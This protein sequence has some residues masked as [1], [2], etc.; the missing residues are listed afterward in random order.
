MLVRVISKFDVG[1]E[2]IFFGR[3]SPVDRSDRWTCM[4]IL[5]GCT[6]FQKN[7]AAISKFQ[8]PYMLHKASSELWTYKC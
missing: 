2:W 7:Q 8:A 6:N 3:L 1:W 4:V 5:L